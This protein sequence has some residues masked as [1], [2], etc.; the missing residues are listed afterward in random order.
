MFS[1]V[2]GPSRHTNTE[3]VMKFLSDIYQ[4]ETIPCHHHPPWQTWLPFCTDRDTSKHLLFIS[5]S[6][7]KTHKPHLPQSKQHGA[8]GEDAG[9]PG[10]LGAEDAVG[11]VAAVVEGCPQ[12]GR[13]VH[14]PGHVVI[15]GGVIQQLASAGVI[16]QVLSCPQSYIQQRNVIQARANKIGI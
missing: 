12:V 16:P 9:L 7:W 11:V 2:A 14:C 1:T 6:T 13:D 3:R 8:A 4:T 15:P 5:N 10:R